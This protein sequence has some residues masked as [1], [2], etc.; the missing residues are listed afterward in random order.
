M[1]E[2]REKNQTSAGPFISRWWF[3]LFQI[4]SFLYL[5]KWSKLTNKFAETTVLD[6]HFPE[7]N[8]KSSWQMVAKGDDPFFLG[9]KRPI[10]RAYLRF[11]DGIDIHKIKNSGEHRFLFLAAG[12]YSS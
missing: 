10:F 8:S 1:A 4:I 6:L 3:Q 12:C 9:P 2:G 5:R 11:R 7:T